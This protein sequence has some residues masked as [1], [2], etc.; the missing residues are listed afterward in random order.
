MA[1]TRWVVG[2]EDEGVPVEAIVARLRAARGPRGDEGDEV[3]EGR[4]F[5]GG[6]RATVGT[7]VRAGDRVEIWDRRT[8][9]PG[10]TRRGDAHGEPRQIAGAAPPG[11]V[12]T[13]EPLILARAG[14]V[15]LAAKPAGLAT[16][17]ERRGGDSLI[18]RLAARA[19][20]RAAHAASRLDVD[21]SGVVA[22]ALGPRGA[23][24]L[25]RAQEAG[26]LR[27]VYV[28]IAAGELRDAGTWEAAVGGK[29]A[30]TRWSALAH[31]RGATWLELELVTG[32]T[33]QIRE[34]AAA[35]GAALWG[36]AAHGGERRFAAHGG[37]MHEVRRP[38]L[39]AVAARLDDGA[40]P[41][42]EASWPPPDDLRSTWLAL[43]GAATAWEGWL[44]PWR[45]PA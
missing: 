13:V 7:R 40:G 8:A 22:C 39:H 43:D 20:V 27:R 2:A 19:R 38:M 42:L 3:A 35:V 4:V 28:A 23:A 26:S 18:S 9:Q 31:A 5:V 36:D 44:P 32:R 21:V 34:H 15:V 11:A 41:P 6:R 1:S 17:P 12:P 29:P 24:R 10:D 33:H 14:E 37:S 25:A 16:E 30:V 45:R